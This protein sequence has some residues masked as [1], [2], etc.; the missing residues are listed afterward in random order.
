MKFLLDESAD[1][2]LIDFLAERGHDV[3]AIARDYPNALPDRQVLSLARRERRVLITNDL[4]FGDLI[5]RERL[6]HRG[7]ILFR[8]RNTSLAGKQ[9]RLEF[10]LAN[11]QDRLDEFLTVTDDRVRSR[12]S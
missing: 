9:R 11:Y 5:V 2:R 7:V 6:A 10:V 8:L 3:T 4:D 12:R 1:Q